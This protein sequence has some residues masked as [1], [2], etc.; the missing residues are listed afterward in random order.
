M[1][2]T[3]EF[4]AGQ[5]LISK[6]LPIKINLISFQE[7]SE[8]LSIDGKPLRKNKFIETK[9]LIVNA[10]R[11]VNIKVLA[12]NSQLYPITIEM[13]AF[14]GLK[15]YS[16]NIYDGVL[17]W[18][19]ESKGNVAI[20]KGHAVLE[21]GVSEY[22]AIYTALFQIFK[23]TIPDPEKRHRIASIILNN[24]IVIKQNRNF[25]AIQTDDGYCTIIEKVCG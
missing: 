22:D 19:E 18:G 2:T 12:A 24:E 16:I 23:D 17:V 6:I 21:P 5:N 25:K 1:I 3:L 10:T 15:D 4:K 13:H 7:E 14:N 8:C 9:D 20:D 11:V